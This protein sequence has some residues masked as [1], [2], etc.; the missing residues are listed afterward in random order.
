MF[1]S[2]PWRSKNKDRPTPNDNEEKHCSQ[3][4]GALPSIPRAHMTGVRTYINGRGQNTNTSDTME[5]QVIHDEHYD[6][7][8]PLRKDDGSLLGRI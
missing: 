7:D 8:W 2:S 3:F 6:D 5:S 4:D 1:V